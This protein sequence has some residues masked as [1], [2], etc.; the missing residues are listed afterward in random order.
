MLKLGLI[1]EY[2]L[3]ADRR[4]AFTPS[5]C[6]ELQKRFPDLQIIV[7]SSPDRIFTDVD[8]TSLGIRVQESIS[9][10]DILMGIKEVP[11]YKLIAG[12][13]YLFFSH[14]IKKQEH[15]RQMLQEILKQS[16][17]LID[18][19]C[20]HWPNGARVLGFG[21]YAGWVGAYEAFKA[22]G[23]RSKVFN[24]KPAFTFPNFDDV[25]KGLAE[26]KSSISD[27]KLRIVVS[28][29][30]RVS[31]GSEDVLHFLEIPKV[32]PADFIKTKYSETVYTLLDTFDLYER[33]NG[34]AWDHDHFFK[35][36]KDY[37]SLFERY[38]YCTD[39][40]INGVFWD[41]DM[42]RHFTKENTALPGF[43][44]QTI[45]DISCDIEG[46]VPITLRDTS[47]DEPVMGWDPLNQC[48]CEPY[49]QGCIDIMAVSN[50]PSEIPA[51]ASEGFGKDLMQEVI[52]A[53]LSNDSLMID[54]ATICRNGQLTPHYQYL[55]D[56]VNS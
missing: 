26:H 19:E 40:L 50:L 36:H 33:K 55:Q 41:K 4:V 17:R 13:T 24:L 25:K 27:L 8:Y 46:S 16:I 11:A 15:N 22:F 47:M 51:D 43:S 56:Y 30:G 29:S 5:Q 52:P 53:L 1:R 35:N 37:K 21:K 39:I 7:E 49:K 45:A 18:Y 42:P 9:E 10:C 12:K 32:S 44:I 31:S 14:T 48:E 34:G 3:P 54:Q 20:L 6:V 38:I 23:L 28:G 2:K